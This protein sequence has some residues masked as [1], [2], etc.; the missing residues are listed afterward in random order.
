[1]QTSPAARRGDG[2]GELREL[3]EKAA[4]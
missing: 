3:A 4:A 2:E 1:V